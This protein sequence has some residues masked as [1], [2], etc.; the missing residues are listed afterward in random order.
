[1]HKLTCVGHLSAAFGAPADSSHH[2]PFLSFG[3]GISMEMKHRNWGYLTFNTFQWWREYGESSLPGPNP[4]GSRCCCFLSQ[5]EG[6]TMLPYHNLPWPDRITWL[7]PIFSP[8]RWGSLDFITDFPAS[9][10]LLLVLNGERQIAG[11]TAGPQLRSPDLAHC[12]LRALAV[13]VR[14]CLCQREGV[15]IECQNKC[16]IPAARSV[17]CYVA[18]SEHVIQNAKYGQQTTGKMTFVYLQA[19]LNLECFAELFQWYPA[20]PLFTGGFKGFSLEFQTALPGVLDILGSYPMLTQLMFYS[21][22]QCSVPFL[23]VDDYM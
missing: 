3:F 20:R 2:Q 23:V 16:Q 17:T 5:A 12:P 6:E 22:E 10:P 8:T 15:R 11:G 19:N 1:M 13:E 9:S 14:Q 4:A 7:F 18:L 21:L